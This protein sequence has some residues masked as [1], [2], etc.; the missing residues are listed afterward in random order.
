VAERGRLE[1]EGRWDALIAAVD[2]LV[3]D[4]ADDG[5]PGCRLGLDYL[6]ASVVA[7]PVAPM[8]RTTP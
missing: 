5:G 3:A 2:A 6:L 8:T 1:D 7:G 4:H